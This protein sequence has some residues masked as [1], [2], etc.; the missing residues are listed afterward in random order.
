MVHA[1][2]RLRGQDP[3]RHVGVQASRLLRLLEACAGARGGRGALRHGQLRQ[4]AVARRPA[5]REDVRRRSAQGDAAQPGR[6]QGAR[7]TQGGG[8]EAAARSATR[9]A[10]GAGEGPARA[11]RLRRLR[12]QPPAR[13]RRADRG[14]Q[15]RR[16]AQ[17]ARGAG[18]GTA[19]RGQA[20]PL[21][22]PTPAA[23]AR[24]CP[25]HRR[26]LRNLRRFRGVRSRQVP[27]DMRGADRLAPRAPPR[28][29]TRR[30]FR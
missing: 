5:G 19:G 7:C 26:A 30:T 17:P 25:A 24:R 6:H 28:I 29:E 1:D 9:P 10:H 8:A 20:P 3:G 4:A 16:D 27:K 14:G 11:G 12:P 18:G 23:A 13:V 21:E 22:V 15:A 2:V